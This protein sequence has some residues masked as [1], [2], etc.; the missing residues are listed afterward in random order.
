M[1]FKFPT[2][3]CAAAM[4][5]A[6][7]HSLWA[8]EFKAADIEII[9]PSSRATPPNA[10]V[11]AGYVVLQNKGTEADR[12]VAVTGEIA[13]R[14]EIHEMAV[15]GNGVM[16]MRPLPEGIEIPAGGEIALEPGSYH[17]MFMDLERTP[18]EGEP[19]AGTLT[20]EKAGTVEVEFAVDGMGKSSGHGSQGHDG[21][22]G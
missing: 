18:K 10:R 6:S 5:V 12:L 21:H 4:L 13:G 19:F 9:H 20:F 11:A 15:D 17:I 22:G 1:I 8:H 14:T 3:A 7:T 2:A 16:T